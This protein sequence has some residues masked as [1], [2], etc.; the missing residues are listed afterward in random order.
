MARE[1][2]ALRHLLFMGLLAGIPTIIG[3]WIGGFSYSPIAATFFLA[4][5]AGAMLVVVYE[6]WKMVGRQREG[7]MTAPLNAAGLGLGLLVMY[8]TALM[9]VA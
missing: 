7:G 5:G 9:V 2:P 4:L 6:I 3:T 1:R 8:A